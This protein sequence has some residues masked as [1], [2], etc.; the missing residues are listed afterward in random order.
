M[1]LTEEWFRQFG[2]LN[3]TIGDNGI[4]YE[5]HTTVCEFLGAN[6]PLDVDFNGDGTKMYVANAGTVYE[7][8]VP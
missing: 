6:T 4:K 1:K 3:S 7:Y 5:L 8:N 2:R